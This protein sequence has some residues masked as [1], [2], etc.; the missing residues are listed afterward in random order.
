MG[1]KKNFIENQEGSEK[2]SEYLHILFDDIGYRFRNDLEWQKN[3]DEQFKLFLYKVID[4]VHESIEIMVRD[5][6]NKYTDKMLI[7]LI[8]SKA[9]NDLQLIRINGSV[10]GGLVGMLIFS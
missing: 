10:V 5:N 4:G 1:L 9:G 8:E 7:D 3:V 2:T 6:L